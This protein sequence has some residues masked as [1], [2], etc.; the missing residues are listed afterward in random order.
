MDAASI[1]SRH[2]YVDADELRRTTRIHLD[3]SQ[4]QEQLLQEQQLQPQQQPQPTFLQVAESWRNP[5]PDGSAYYE[6]CLWCNACT[7]PASGCIC[8]HC[9]AGRVNHL[10]AGYSAVWSDLLLA[11]ITR[12]RELR[13]FGTTTSAATGTLTSGGTSSD[14]EESSDESDDS[15]SGSAPPRGIL[16]VQPEHAAAASSYFNM[17]AAKPAARPAPQIDIEVALA[18]VTDDSAAVQELASQLI[19]LCRCGGS[20]NASGVQLRR[21]IELCALS[22]RRERARLERLLTQC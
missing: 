11:P 4:Q 15:L 9:V 22:Q 1:S 18:S 20:I 13:L 2:V 8:K 7:C 14:S 21:M 17:L 12:G 5:D 16:R 10:H 6:Y 19:T 3:L